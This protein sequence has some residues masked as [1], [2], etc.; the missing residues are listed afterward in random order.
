VL[1]VVEIKELLDA[2]RTWGY[3][4][5]IPSF[6]YLSHAKLWGNMYAAAFSNCVAAES[7]SADL[8]ENTIKRLDKLMDV[9]AE[10]EQDDDTD[11][12]NL[13]G[14]MQG[15]PTAGTILE[16]FEFP[17]DPIVYCES[18]YYGLIVAFRS[19]TFQSL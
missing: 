8:K 12:T 17:K 4:I 9:M 11:T 18:D 5:N 10:S 7:S 6:E 3:K 2:I 1:K 16:T 14:A 19:P 15:I 13:H